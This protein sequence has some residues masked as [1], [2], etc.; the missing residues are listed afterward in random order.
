MIA[1]P[2]MVSTFPIVRAYL[3]TLAG[4]SAG[5]FPRWRCAPTVLK[6]ALIRRAVLLGA[7]AMLGG[8]TSAAAPPGIVLRAPGIED[9][10]FVMA[11]GMGLP[12][13]AWIPDG[14]PWAVVLAL[15]GFNDSRDAWALPAPN[16][17][18]AG[19]AVYAPDQR[20]F[21]A[22]A[23]RGLWPGADALADDATAMAGVLRRRYPRARLVLMGES[24]GGAVLM[25]LATRGPVPEVDAMVLLAP[26]VWGRAAMNWFMQGGLWLAA[27]FAPGLT[28][29]RPPPGVRIV[30]SDNVE[31]LRALGR[32]PL[33][34]K[35][36]RFDTLRGLVGLMDL[37]L[38]AG[39]RFPPLPALFL[40]GGKDTIIPPA[41]TRAT[42]SALPDDLVQRG[43]VRRSFYPGG[44]HLLPRDLGRAAV[45]GDILAWLR[46]PVGALPSRGEA[47]A[48]AWL[49]DARTDER[50]VIGL[51]PDGHSG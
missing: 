13:R 47:A 31:A 10:A 27:N 41:A 7:A 8:C 50:R 28:V 12:Y 43:V 14:D 24:M 9:G 46:D 19:V 40:Y 36:T 29:S 42:W 23:A 49:S 45:I 17:A 2:G 1:M 6:P 18:A 16:I 48:V 33:T 30:A 22:T 35:A 3:R 15:H 39:S 38:A 4:R 21:G 25:H 20:G 11:D 5:A 26:A 51:P 32:N 37:A 34:I 44:Y